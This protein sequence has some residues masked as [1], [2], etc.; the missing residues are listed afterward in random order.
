[1][2]LGAVTP[3]IWMKLT[4]IALSFMIPLVVTTYFL[5]RE[6]NINVHFA[7]QELRGD[8]YLL[9]ISQLL[10][11]LEL[12]R[13]LVRDQDLTQASRAEQLVD[14]DFE[15]LL[16]TDRHLAG[17]LHTTADELNERDRGSSAPARLKATWETVKLA[18]DPA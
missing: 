17:K 1:M 2:R 6:E 4:A 11:H 10:V 5:V 9:P 7:E 13:A 3:R 12:H 18:A 16:S 14:S 15:V 8:R